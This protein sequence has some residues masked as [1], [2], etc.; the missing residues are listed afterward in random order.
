[1][2][3]HSD[4]TTLNYFV[5]NLCHYDDESCIETKLF[6]YDDYH[7]VIKVIKEITFQRN[8]SIVYTFR[9]FQKCPLYRGV[10]QSS[11]G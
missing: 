9:T 8:L 2:P 1:M 3:I 6:S 11:A 5:I 7:V 10:Y 4:D